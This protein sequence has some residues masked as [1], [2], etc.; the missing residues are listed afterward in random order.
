MKR[1]LQ[2][3]MNSNRSAPRL[4]LNF[5]SDDNTCSVAPCKKDKFSSL[6]LVF[7]V[8]S[9]PALQLIY[10]QFLQDTDWDPH[11]CIPVS[12]NDYISFK[13]SFDPYHS[14]ALLSM[15]RSQ[16]TSLCST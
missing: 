2:D 15:F 11:V 9:P 12:A 6:H 14:D 7:V 1:A 16:A 10:D 13:L 4:R 8:F 3:T 5:V